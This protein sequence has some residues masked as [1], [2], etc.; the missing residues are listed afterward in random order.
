M[1]VKKFRARRVTGAPKEFEIEYDKVVTPGETPEDEPIE[2]RQESQTFHAVP[3]VPGK[4]LLEVGASMAGGQEDR[5]HAINRFLDRVIVPAEKR[6]WD[7][8]MSDTES[9]LDMETLA[10]ITNWLIE[11]Y[12][13]EHP[14]EQ[15]KS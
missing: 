13:D 2:T 12:N 14:T 7:D 10:D 5:V 9:I 8:V 15:S 6:R 11:E 4:W 3:E 1:A